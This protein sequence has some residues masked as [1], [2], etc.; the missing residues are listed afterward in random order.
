MMHVS[1]L[2]YSANNHTA[3]VLA[4]K[5]RNEFDFYIFGGFTQVC[6]V[7]SSYCIMVLLAWNHVI[8]HLSWKQIEYDVWCQ[9]HALIFKSLE[10]DAAELTRCKS[11]LH[12]A[13]G[14]NP[15]LLN[16]FREDSEFM[17]RMRVNYSPL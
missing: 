9:K 11:L 15:L 17:V 7:F 8:D 1:V 14:G 3:R 10:S 16:S 13:S 2:G 6:F 5:L 4:S 12:V